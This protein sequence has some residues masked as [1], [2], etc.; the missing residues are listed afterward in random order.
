MVG[1]SAQGRCR[2]KT[3]TLANVSALSGYCQARDG[4]TLAFSILQDYVNPYTEH[5]LQ[6]AMA[7]ALVRYNG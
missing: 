1:T 7:E 5:P 2:G 4:H 3:G 6:D